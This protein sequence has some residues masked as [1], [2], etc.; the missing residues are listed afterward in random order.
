MEF[1]CVDDDFPHIQHELYAL[2]MDSCMLTFI[3]VSIGAHLDLQD[4]RG[5]TALM[6][7]SRRGTT[8]I[9]LALI[10]AGTELELRDGIRKTA[11]VV[12]TER[13]NDEIAD[14]ISNKQIRTGSFDKT[15]LDSAS[16][17][18]CCCSCNLM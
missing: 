8:D 1:L 7:A 17:E 13:G 10:D 16:K 11:F 4:R 3:P 12:A 5:T 18:D 14:A 2:A 9:A 15:R 6:V